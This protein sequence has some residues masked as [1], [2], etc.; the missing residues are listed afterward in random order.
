MRDAIKDAANVAQ[1]R[2]AAAPIQVLGAH[3]GIYVEFEAIPDWELAIKSFENLR[4]RDPH[5]R[6]EVVAVRTDVV[7]ATPTTPETTV[8]RATVFVPDGKIASFIQRFETYA[9][10]TP[11][12]PKEQRGHDF[13]DRC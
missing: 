12:R 1:Q 3:A 10:P 13:V 11:P 4:V 2:R 8:Q 6:V 9:Q 7:A 5:E